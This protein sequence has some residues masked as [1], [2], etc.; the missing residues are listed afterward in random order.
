MKKYFK[1]P[2]IKILIVFVSAFIL[3]QVSFAYISVSETAEILK[4]DHYRLGVI[5]QVLLSN[6]T[7]SNSSNIGVFM[8][9]P[10]ENDINT[11]F[12]IGSGHT[13]FWTSASVKWVPYPDYDKQP[14]MGLR[15]ALIYARDE[16]VDFYNIQLTPLISKIVQTEEWGTMTPYVGVPVTV[17]HHGSSSE[18]VMQFAIGSEWNERQDFQVGAEFDLNLSDTNIT[19]NSLTFHI[20]FP[21]DGNVGFRK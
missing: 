21:F 17:V 4:T 20:N 1:Q 3:T 10:V 12:I 9:L 18:T 11:R 5:P 7:G 6:S 15:G 2:L 8:D 13:S 16:R 14:A 19:S